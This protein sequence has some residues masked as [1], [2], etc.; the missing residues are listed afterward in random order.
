MLNLFPLRSHNNLHLWHHHR[1]KQS[2][3]SA[4]WRPKPQRGWWRRRER[5]HREDAPV[6]KRLKCLIGLSWSSEH[7][8]HCSSVHSYTDYSREQDVCLEGVGDSIG[9]TAPVFVDF[10]LTVTLKGGGSINKK[11]D[12][13]KIGKRQLSWLRNR[14]QQHVKIEYSNKKQVF[15]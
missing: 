7:I 6:V 13:R 14:T 12:L 11:I 1:R 10:N 2:D 4:A 15:V 5:Q 9:F 3:L 8:H